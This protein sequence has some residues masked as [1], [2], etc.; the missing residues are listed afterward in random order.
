[1]TL[2]QAAKHYQNPFDITKFWKVKDYPLIPVGKMV[3][4]K[5]PDD[6][7]AQVEQVAFSPSRMVPGIQPSPDRMLHASMMSYPDA[8]HYRLGAN[9]AQIPI[10]QCPF[11]SNTY[12]QDS[13]MNDVTNGLIADVDE[14]D[15][16]FSLPQ[17]YLENFVDS[18]ERKRICKNIASF[19]GKADIIVQKDFL[20][21]IAYKVSNEFGDCLN[22][23]LFS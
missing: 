21:K 23:A 8:Q 3:L 13:I 5:N 9:W 10:N 2:K 11:Q 16:N 12:Y 14:D 7:F 17:Y 1:M 22:G 19:L 15:D 4:N 6:Y 18:G 20:N